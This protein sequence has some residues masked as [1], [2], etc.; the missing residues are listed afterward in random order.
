MPA[1]ATED[2][3]KHGPTPKRGKKRKGNKYAP[4]TWGE[5]KAATIELRVPSGQL[6]LV[7]TVGIPGLIEAGILDR[8]DSL[9]SMVAEEFVK[10]DNDGNPILDIPGL[11]DSSGAIMSIMEVMDKTLCLA[12]VEPKVYE[13]P[14]V[15]LHE[16]PDDPDS[17]VVREDPDDPDS[18]AKMVEGEREDG[19]VYTDTVDDEDKAFIFQVVV[20]GTQDLEQFR[21]RVTE[22]V[23][24]LDSEPEVGDSS[25]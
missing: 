12:V 19:K 5:K 13:V 21:G 11:T 2:R 8:I 24:G 16:D 15:E 18:P 3:Q 17:P 1:Q 23:G 22:L 9:T 14:M 4:V 6:C 7:R 10:R 25:E 20:G